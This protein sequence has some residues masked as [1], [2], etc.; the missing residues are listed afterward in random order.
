MVCTGNAR[1]GQP[2]STSFYKSL[3]RAL[4][5]AMPGYAC[6]LLKD[7]LLGGL[8]PYNTAIIK[9]VV[10]VLVQVIVQILRKKYY[11]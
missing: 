2:F 4:T 9:E 1:Q 6:L 7:N 8:V 11:H 5:A 10:Q 3:Q